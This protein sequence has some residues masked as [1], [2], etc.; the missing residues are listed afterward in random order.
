MEFYGAIHAD[1]QTYPADMGFATVN[2][3]QM[4]TEYI[5]A[6][7]P[8]LTKASAVA[9]VLEDVAVC[10]LTCKCVHS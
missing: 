8:K 3:W 6:V 5:V 4:T 10:N 1:M 7:T 9:F 2:N